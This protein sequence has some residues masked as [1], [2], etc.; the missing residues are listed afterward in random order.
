MMNIYRKTGKTSVNAWGGEA[1]LP[2]SLFTYTLFSLLHNHSSFEDFAEDKVLNLAPT[3]I[4]LCSLMITR[5]R[6]LLIC[7]HVTG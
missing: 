3:N 4:V 6:V 1:S 7:V 5:T 2:S